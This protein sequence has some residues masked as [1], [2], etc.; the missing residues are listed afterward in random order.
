VKRPLEV[1]AVLLLAVLLPAFGLGA[2]GKK[3]GDDCK[4]SVDCNEEENVRT[5]DLSQPGGYCTVDGCDEISCPEEAVCVRFFP[6]MEFLNKSCDPAAAATCEP[7]ELCV[8]YADGGRCVPRATESRKCVLSCDNDGDCRD[9][10]VCRTT[11]QGNSV[12][13]TPNPL[14][15]AR[16]CSPRGFQ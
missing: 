4:D 16:F 9:E 10:Y 15:Q 11:G 5:C 12:A 7:H 13:L 1:A 2:C 14:A 6:A 3:I 8:R